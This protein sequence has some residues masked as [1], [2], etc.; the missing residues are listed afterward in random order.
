MPGHTYDVTARNPRTGCMG[1]Y[2]FRGVTMQEAITVAEQAGLIVLG[3]QLAESAGATHTC[4]R[5]D[6]VGAIH[7]VSIRRDISSL[8]GWTLVY[9][10]VPLRDVFHC[11]YCG[12]DLRALLDAQPK[13][14]ST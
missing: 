2:A 6:D 8:S 10:N 5:M 13:E 14:R 4:R 3:A 1:V 7:V 9:R 11:P 12:A